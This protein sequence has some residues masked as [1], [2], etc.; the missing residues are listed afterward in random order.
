MEYISIGMD[1]E[2]LLT[3]A[4]TGLPV[5]ACGLFG[6]TKDNPLPVPELGEG[7]FIQEDNV[8]LEFNIP[9]QYVPVGG[10][11]VTGSTHKVRLN[12][13]M[14]SYHE[15]ITKIKKYIE[16][17]ALSKQLIVN[18]K[19]SFS[20]ENLHNYAEA[21]IVG[22]MPDKN[23]YTGKYN[24]ARNAYIM[25]KTRT[26]AA[27][28]H[29]GYPNP[30]E[31]MNRKIA[32]AMDITMGMLAAST[33]PDKSRK[34]YYGRAGAYRD[35]P[36][37]VEYRCLP[38]EYNISEYEHAVRDVIYAYKLAKKTTLNTLIVKSVESKSYYI[39]NSV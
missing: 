1:A 16:E 30:T 27:H 6:G 2:V 34:L 19:S 7:F 23:A 28:I 26:A 31:K 33:Y 37:G 24:P 15:N 12:Q 4:A 36:Y 14:L 13:G 25:G 35:K 8:A 22:C 39:I 32:I 18:Y 9:P 5:P 38:A 10:P 11:L 21:M 3:S 20:Y 29:I 17:L